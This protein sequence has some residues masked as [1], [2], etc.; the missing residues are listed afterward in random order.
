VPDEFIHHGAQ[1]IQRR[2]LG[3]DAEGLTETI[4][5]HLPK[6]EAARER[7]LIA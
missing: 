7:V 5:R 4:R 1:K 2:E 6:V 3:L